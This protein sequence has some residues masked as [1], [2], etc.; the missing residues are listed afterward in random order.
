MTRAL[1]I[2]SHEGCDLT[3]A[4]A[5]VA[6]VHAHAERSEE[7]HVAI[8]DLG[9]AQGTW[10]QR[11]GQWVRLLRAELGAEDRIRCGEVELDVNRLLSLFG[12][13]SSIRLRDVR[14]RGLPADQP[15][16]PVFE[17]PRRNPETGKIEEER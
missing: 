12:E 4:G 15:V 2:G 10:L 1:T 16:R 13:R 3:I 11:N 7:G 9:S 14:D 6:P 8:V 5:G 17:R